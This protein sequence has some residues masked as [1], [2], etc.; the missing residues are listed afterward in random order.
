MKI[1]SEV[2]DHLKTLLKMDN[3]VGWRREVWHILKN[4]EL[5]S[6]TSVTPEQTE[7]PQ[8]ERSESD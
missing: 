7:E 8:N 3:T 1:D 5:I 4:A 6:E 2:R